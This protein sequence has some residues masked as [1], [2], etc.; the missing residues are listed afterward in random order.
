MDTTATT[1]RPSATLAREWSG[2]PT[3]GFVV[4]SLDRKMIANKAR[5]Q[6]AVEAA[7]EAGYRIVSQDLS[8][9]HLNFDVEEGPE[10]PDEFTAW[11]LSD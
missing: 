6:D 8:T 3:P 1:F 11:L 7:N 9:E 2:L 4:R 10:D 5:Y